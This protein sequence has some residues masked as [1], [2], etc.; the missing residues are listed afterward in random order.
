MLPIEQGLNP[1]P[2]D[3]HNWATK[4]TQACLSQYLGYY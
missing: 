4:A 2:H 1:Q 3:W